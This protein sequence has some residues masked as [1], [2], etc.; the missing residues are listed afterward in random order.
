MAEKK[1][2]KKTPKKPTRGSASATGLSAEE[3]AAL[4]ETIADQKAAAR[5]L[6][7]EAALLA[8]I[9]A[10]KEPDRGMAKKIHA[11]VK[12]NA[13]SL[14][15]TTWYG[16][17]AYANKAGKA[18]CFFQDAAKFKARYATLGFNDTANLDDGELWPIAFALKELTPAG[19]AK[20]AALLKK[21]AR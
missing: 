6:E 12:S 3:K 21:A 2:A 8:K 15:P 11:I 4:K 18:V 1:A 19:E 14:S 5:G 16:M 20:I 10:M 17:P 13:P 9:A 7:G